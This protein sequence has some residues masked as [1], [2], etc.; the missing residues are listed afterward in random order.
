MMLDVDEEEEQ[1]RRRREEE[2]RER[3]SAGLTDGARIKREE[4]EDVTMPLATPMSET[5]ASRDPDTREAAAFLLMLR[6]IGAPA[7]E[8]PS[9]NRPSALPLNLS[10]PLTPPQASSSR[11][12][13]FSRGGAKQNSGQHKRSRAAAD[14]TTKSKDNSKAARKPT[15][16]LDA[17]VKLDKSKRS[18][19]GAPL[20]HS[21]R[22]TSTSAPTTNTTDGSTGPKR[23][24]RRSAPIAGNLSDVLRDPSVM[25]VAGFYDPVLGKYRAR[26]S[27]AEGHAASPEDISPPVLPS[28]T[29]TA[30][31]ANSNEISPVKVSTS[32]SVN[33]AMTQF[34][35]SSTTTVIR[36]KVETVAE[37]VSRIKAASETVGDAAKNGNLAKNT[38]SEPAVDVT[39]IK[40]SKPPRDAVEPSKHQSRVARVAVNGT[41]ETEKGKE[42]DNDK[43]KR[44]VSIGNDDRSRRKSAPSATTSALNVSSPRLRSALHNRAK[45]RPTAGKDTDSSRTLAVSVRGT[46][47]TAPIGTSLAALMCSPEVAAVSGAFDWESRR[48]VSRR[49][50]SFGGVTVRP[51]E[52]LEDDS[53]GDSQDDEVEARVVKDVIDSHDNDDDSDLSEVS[54]V[55]TTTT[56]SS[57][58]PSDATSLVTAPVKIDVDS[59]RGSRS[60]NPITTS[61]S[62]LVKNPIV[63]AATGGWDSSAGRYKGIRKRPSSTSAA[64]A[65]AADSADQVIH[66]H[67]GDVDD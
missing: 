65:A 48:Y 66:S 57:S 5:G 49:A 40:G 22:S 31:A 27:L 34:P 35:T 54:E 25:N 52:P 53:N 36:N 37:A 24:T 41:A 62:D 17:N 51:P 20:Q 7:L 46:R 11:G 9:T 2:E 43:G 63:L 28:P 59:P 32:E 26:G 38:H 15:K 56:R 23:G 58:R 50:A 3:A 44:A 19:E 18:A 10:A 33:D 64:A 60:R 42:A 13:P 12:S 45:D 39:S 1:R 29:R 47:S 30:A 14:Q 6:S 21:N 67:G 8:L 16:S 55:A 4:T 61:V